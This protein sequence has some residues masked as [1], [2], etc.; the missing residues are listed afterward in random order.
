[1]SIVVLASCN[2]PETSWEGVLMTNYGASFEDFKVVTGAQGLL[3]PGTELYQV[4][5]WEQTADPNEKTITTSN[6]GRFVVDPVYQYSATR[7]AGPKI[8]FNYKQLKDQDG[9]VFMDKIEGNVL[10]ILVQNAY[11][12]TSGR[13]TTDSIM[14]NRLAY[15]KEVESVVKLAFEEKGFTLKTLTSGLT[16][17]ASMMAAIEAR[18]NSIQEAERVRNELQVSQL[19][20]Q[21][22]QID[23]QTNQ[24]KAQGY[25][26]EYLMDKY[27]DAIRYS[28]NKVI[29]VDGSKLPQINIMQ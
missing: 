10:N 9:T 17:P 19:Q 20:Q 3:G 29:I 16:P 12:E 2:R 7:N 15:E 18:N 14:N 13:Y 6:S 22:A 11:Q 24:I 21:K 25:S 1:M 5:M 28:T 8:I 23:Q 26:K 27:I 4:P